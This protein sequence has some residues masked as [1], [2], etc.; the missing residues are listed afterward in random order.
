M[1]DAAMMS[2]SADGP[3]FT[4]PEFGSL[5]AVLAPFST[6]L[7]VLEKLDGFVIPRQMEIPRL[8]KWIEAIRARPSVT[9]SIP[10]AEEHVEFVMGIFHS[11][12]AIQMHLQ[13]LHAPPK[14]PHPRAKSSENMVFSSNI[15]VYESWRFTLG[16]PSRAQRAYDL[17][18]SSLR[19]LF[20]GSHVHY[21]AQF[22][23]WLQS[24]SVGQWVIWIFIGTIS[25]NHI[26]WDN[27]K[28]P[29]WLEQFGPQ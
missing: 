27:W 22:D 24:S 7:L 17:G 5:D 19:Q 29:S 16:G 3:F 25:G 18:K 15:L 28:R 9:S 23:S 12:P 1:V 11:K 10:S 20:R 2:Y 4:G 6:S 26:D 13:E 8:H 21:L 14:F